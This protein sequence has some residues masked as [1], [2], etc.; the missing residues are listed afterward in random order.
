MTL[1]LSETLP[2]T[3][4]RGIPCEMQTTNELVSPFGAGILQDYMRDGK[5]K[6]NKGY[7]QRTIKAAQRIAE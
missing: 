6:A 2:R 5:R 3:I 7:L 4:F 1:D